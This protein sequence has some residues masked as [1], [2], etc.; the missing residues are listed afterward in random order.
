VRT[1]TLTRIVVALL[2]L[3]PSVAAAQPDRWLELRSPHFV[4][5]SNAGEEKAR[6]VA[7]E[8][9][10]A[11]EVFRGIL[12]TARSDARRPVVVL[13]V[14]NEDG[15]GELLPQFLERKGPRP[16]AAYWMG[17]HEHHLALRADVSAD[18]RARRV[19][20]EYVH[21]LTHLNVPDPPAWLDEG[22]SELWGTVVVEGGTVEVGRPA[23]DHLKTLRARRAWI[24]LDELLAMDAPDARDS[25]RVSMFYAQS[26]ALTHCLVL[27]ACLD[28]TG[29]A[30]ASLELAPPAY[31]DEL[32]EGTGPIDAARLAFGDL[33]ALEETLSEYVRAG[34]FRALRIVAHP[35][36]GE[37]DPAEAGRDDARALT[38]A[39]ALVIRAG[40]LMDGERPAAALPL[41]TEALR[42]EPGDPAVLE[43]MG[44]YHFQR[45]EPTEA[46]RWFD[47]A[48][49]SERVGYI[50]HYYRA[51]LARTLPGEV[52]EED[53][54][55]R[56]VTLNDA[57]APAYA[58]LAGVLARDDRPAEAVEAARRAV[59]LEPEN[60]AYRR[61]VESLV[62]PARGTTGA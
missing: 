37:D 56:A 41:L 4:V 34:R 7:R 15:L 39:E 28:R 21:L 36:D 26:W 58:R 32:R 27:G 14:R 38:P 11:R 13:A 44:R 20:H 19:F 10:R 50:A 16:A 17:P 24:P 62:E 60:A 23:P 53:H 57:F 35:Q 46:V 12:D 43:M 49:E 55:R 25:K 45:N 47:R 42:L 6:S 29:G 40:F 48:I 2:A 51:I 1:W 30:A 59:E 5:V 61:L 52:S 22:L 8:L 33:A 31:V 18:E 3:A 54:L 9:E